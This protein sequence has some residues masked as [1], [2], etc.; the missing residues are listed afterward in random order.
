MCEDNVAILSEKSHK[1]SHWATFTV[2]GYE[3]WD[4]VTFYHRALRTHSKYILCQSY[5]YVD[6]LVTGRGLHLSGHPY[7][8]FSLAV[9]RDDSMTSTLVIIT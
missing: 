5:G 4:L 6:P 2:K 7:I 3:A 9:G 1:V 8:V